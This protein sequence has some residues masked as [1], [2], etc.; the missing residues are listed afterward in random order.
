MDFSGDQNKPNFI[1]HAS[2]CVILHLCNMLLMILSK[3]SAGGLVDL[4][5][6]LKIGRSEKKLRELLT[7]SRIQ[8][9][10]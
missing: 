10:L 1:F 4:E 2:L 8:F 6:Q 9:T 7:Q 3:T 5:Q